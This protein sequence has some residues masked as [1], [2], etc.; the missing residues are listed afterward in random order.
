MR[1]ASPDVLS[2]LLFPSQYLDKVDSDEG[3]YKCRNIKGEGQDRVP[4][5]FVIRSV[6]QGEYQPGKIP[7]SRIS[8]AILYI[9]TGN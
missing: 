3:Q 1:K 4:I 5:V 7:G 2:P 9:N 6:Y 8:V